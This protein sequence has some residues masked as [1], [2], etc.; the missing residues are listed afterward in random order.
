MW[1]TKSVVVIMTVNI[2][3][4]ISVLF[5]VPPSFDQSILIH[6]LTIDQL[7]HCSWLPCAL[8]LQAGKIEILFQLS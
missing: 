4:A 5:V 6:T 2:A 8:S 1:E 3:F 7:K